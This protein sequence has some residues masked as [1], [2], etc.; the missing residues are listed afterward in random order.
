MNDGQQPAM[1]RSLLLGVMV[2]ALHTGCSQP[3][4]PVPKEQRAAIEQEIGI[5]LPPDVILLSVY[6]GKGRDAPDGYWFWVLYSPSG[7]ND[8]F[9]A[10]RATGYS[11]PVSVWPEL[12]KWEQQDWDLE[13][14]RN[15][16]QDSQDEEEVAEPVMELSACWVKGDYFFKGFYLKTVRG[17]YLNI[18]RFTNSEN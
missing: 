10:G 7:F 3:R 5:P 14:L 16:F 9:M 2:L 12:P 13:R 18:K 15:I 6:D 4:K 8:A 17:D 1:W 11:S